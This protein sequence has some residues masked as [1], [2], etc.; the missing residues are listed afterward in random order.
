[1][2][3]NSEYVEAV[4]FHL[5]KLDESGATHRLWRLWTYQPLEEFTVEDANSLGYDNI[6]FP[7]LFLFFGIPGGA[8]LSLVERLVSRLSGKMKQKRAKGAWRRQSI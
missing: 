6:I 4:N 1:M 8:F 3:P 7:F 5:A 2:Q